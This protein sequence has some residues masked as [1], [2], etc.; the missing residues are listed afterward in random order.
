MLLGKRVVDEQDDML[1]EMNANN[2]TYFD[3]WAI[4][5]KMFAAKGYA[6]VY[7]E[8]MPHFGL[9]HYMLKGFVKK[10]ADFYY[11]LFWNAITAKRNDF[12]FYNNPI[13]RIHL[14]ITRRHM[15]T[16]KDRLQFVYSILSQH[17][18]D[19][20]NDIERV[21]EEMVSFWKQLYVG[22]YLNKTV[23]IFCS[24]HGIRFGKIRSSIVGKKCL[25]IF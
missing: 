20:E 17:A 6:T 15:I 14:D 21:D 16:M 3:A 11:H 8:D 1:Q 25:M 23:I 13:A 24:D 5:W 2:E 12:C 10:P 9:F 4:I 19:Y 7:N 18:H 22:G